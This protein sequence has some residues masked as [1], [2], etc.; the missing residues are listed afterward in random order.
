MANGD[1]RRADNR[2]R[3]GWADGAAR[4]L[5]TLALILAIVA[6]IWAWRADLRAGDALNEARNGAGDQQGIERLDPTQNGETIP[7]FEAPDFNLNGNDGDE[8]GN[9]AGNDN[10]QQ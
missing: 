2:G 6:L 3:A 10:Q 7:D 9:G 5:A 4:A 8:G 1:D